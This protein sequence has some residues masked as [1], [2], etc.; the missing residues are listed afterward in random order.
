MAQAQQQIHRIQAAPIPERYARGWHCLGLVS[1]YTDQPVALNYFGGHLVAYRG[2]DGQVHV[3]DGYCPHMGGDLAGGRVEGNSVRCPFHDWSWGA[4]GVCNDIPYAKKIPPRA[5]IK[6][7]PVTEVNGLVFV[8]HDPEERPPIA[9]QYPRE[10]EGFAEGEWTDWVVEK[11]TIQTNC[12]ELIDN[13]ADVAHFGPVHGAPVREFKNIIEGHV[14]SQVLTGGSE[15]LA[16]EGDLYSE[17]TYEGPAYMTTYMEGQLDGQ[18]VVSRLLV[19]HVP[20]DTE[21]FDLRFGVMVR[22]NPSLSEDENRRLAEIYVG[23]N[24]EAFFQDVEI[25]HTKTR[26]DN[27]VLCD[28]DGPVNRLRQWYQQFY[29]DLAEVGDT[30]DERKEYVIEFEGQ[31]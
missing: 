17:A 24:Q 22:K 5:V 18:R 26:V 8:W 30:W 9:E 27:P 1:D 29:Q 16:E 19:S 13:M 12:R 3:L 10:I 4:D 31:R 20:I 28:G 15:R 14:Y 7:W 23:Q 25:W 6:S 11:M 2:E 21:S